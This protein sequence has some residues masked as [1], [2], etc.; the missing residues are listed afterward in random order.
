MLSYFIKPIAEWI[1]KNQAKMPPT[2]VQEAVRR[3]YADN[4]QILVDWDAGGDE[5]ICNIL[6]GGEYNY[7]EKL[8][9]TLSEL[10]I[11]KLFL[12][13]DGDYYNK[14]QGRIDIGENGELVL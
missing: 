3:V 5:T 14:G 8:D 9:R 6:I 12:P 10:V 4:Q 7:I 11:D 13:K 2:S 1:K